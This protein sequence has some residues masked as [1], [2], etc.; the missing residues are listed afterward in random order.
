MMLRVVSRPVLGYLLPVYAILCIYCSYFFLLIKDL[1]AIL[2]KKFFKNKK[3]IKTQNYAYHVPVAIILLLL[4]IQPIIL[5][6]INYKYSDNSKLD[7][8]YLAWNKIFNNIGDDSYLFVF[9]KVSN[10]GSYINLYEQK[11]KRIKFISFK[12]KDYSLD[13]ITEVFNEGKTVYIIG[14]EQSINEK[15]DFEKM[16]LSFELKKMG[17]ILSVKK[18]IGEKTNL[19]L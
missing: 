7:E 1:L 18:I 11:E 17:E 3:T 19:E 16:G 8:A 15:L 2:I 12:D 13:L 5:A 9:S 4:L 10:V 14:N 6:S